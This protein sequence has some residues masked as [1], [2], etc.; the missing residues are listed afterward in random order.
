MNVGEIGCPILVLVLIISERLE[1]LGWVYYLLTFFL[2]VSC[3]ARVRGNP[4]EFDC[5]LGRGDNIMDLIN[6]IIGG[7]WSFNGNEGA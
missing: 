3:D 5:F 1:A 2:W 4:H 7:I 6:F